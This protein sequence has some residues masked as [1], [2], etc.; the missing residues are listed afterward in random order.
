MRFYLIHNL[1]R[2]KQH[3]LQNLF[4]KCN[5]FLSE[6][7]SSVFGRAILEMLSEKHSLDEI[8][9]MDVA[10]LADYLKDK[11]KNRFPD[12]VANCIQKA[13]LASKVRSM[14]RMSFCQS[15]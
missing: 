8:S 13:A 1:K 15:R 7:D 10:D 14:H 4:C 2:E 3:F 6:V 5:E 12:S 11:A 9:N